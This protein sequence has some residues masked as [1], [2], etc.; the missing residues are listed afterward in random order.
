MQQPRKQKPQ[1]EVQRDDIEDTG[2]S[3]LTITEL[4]ALALAAREGPK[5]TKLQKREEALKIE[6]LDAPT[7]KDVEQT[8]SQN[9]TPRQTQQTSGDL[10]RGYLVDIA[11]YTSEQKEPRRSYLEYTTGELSVGFICFVRCGCWTYH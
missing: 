4:D 1:R 11:E 3:V 7:K 6:K 2:D 8:N 9:V 5:E 10:Q